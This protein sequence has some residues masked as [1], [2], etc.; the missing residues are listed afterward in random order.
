[1]VSVN[2]FLKLLRKAVRMILV[3]FKPLTVH[4][5][6][7][8]YNDVWDAIKEKIKNKEIHTWYLMTPENFRDMKNYF[9]LDESRKEIEGK[10]K[11]RYLKM[12]A[13]GER[14]QLH[15]HLHPRLKITYK[16]QDKLIKN[17]IDWLERE[18]GIK[19]SEIVF[20][21]WRWNE[22]SEKIA[23]KYGLKIIEFDDYNSVHDFDWVVNCLGEA[24]ARGE[25]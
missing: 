11:E 20:G 6:A 16:E 24:P 15:V 23:E 17:S 19:V 2:T 1:M 4:T 22:D 12:K 25:F 3:R 18:V 9:W 14:L 8:F 13:W 5:E 7:I 21:W 10:M